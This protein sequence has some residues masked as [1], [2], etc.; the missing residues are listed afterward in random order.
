[1]NFVRSTAIAET[2]ATELQLL[3]DSRV[4]EINVPKPFAR[5][6]R[7]RELGE[8]RGRCVEC[9]QITLGPVEVAFAGDARSAGRVGA[10]R[11]AVV[12]RTGPGAAR[13]RPSRSRAV[14]TRGNGLS[15]VRCSEGARD[16]RGG[17]V[18]KGRL[19]RAFE[20]GL[21]SMG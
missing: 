5:S 15:D 8:R 14:A 4:R 19:T 17:A 12:A 10:R 13:R 18:L 7:G 1:M 6:R 16:A 2:A 9:V 11:S 20:R 3:A 21:D